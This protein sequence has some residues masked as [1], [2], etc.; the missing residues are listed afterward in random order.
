MRTLNETDLLTTETVQSLEDFLL[1]RCPFPWP[2]SKTVYYF[3]L[4]INTTKAPNLLN[5][6]L[7]LGPSVLQHDY[8][9]S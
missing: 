6:N 9:A 5:I 3:I 8:G 7:Q 2:Q 4:F 1:A